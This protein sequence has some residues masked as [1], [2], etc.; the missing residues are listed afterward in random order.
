MADL[1]SGSVSSVS[2]EDWKADMFTTLS[3]KARLRWL[4][5]YVSLMDED[6]LT[7][8]FVSYWRKKRS[9]WDCGC[10]SCMK[11]ERDVTVLLNI[12]WREFTR[13][14]WSQLDVVKD[15]DGFRLLGKHKV[16]QLAV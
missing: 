2:S 9:Y 6:S 16:V 1:D 8:L 11:N 13:R 4:R 10:P 15:G 12:C 7:N 5:K 14:G 3:F